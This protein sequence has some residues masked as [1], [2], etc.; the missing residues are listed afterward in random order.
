MVLAGK[1]SKQALAKGKHAKY[2]VY[3]YAAQFVSVPKF[4][5]RT[6]KSSCQQADKLIFETT[7]QLLEPKIKAKGV[8]HSMQ[9]AETAAC[10]SFFRKADGREKNSR[11]TNDPPA[12]QLSNVK[13]FW[14]WFQSEY[15][16]DKIVMD[17][18]EYF[19]NNGLLKAQ[20]LINGKPLG[21]PVELFGDAGEKDKIELVARLAG[22]IALQ[23]HDASLVS[24]Y[25]NV[26][27]RDDQQISRVLTPVEVNMDFRSTKIMQENIKEVSESMLASKM[28]DLTPVEPSRGRKNQ[29]QSSRQAFCSLALRRKLESF[30]KDPKHE[31]L[32]LQKA[33]LPV[34]CYRNKVIDL[35]EVSIFSIIMGDT[36]SGKTTQVPQIV[37]EHAIAK[38]LGAECNIM[39]TQPRR[40]AA[41]SVAHRVASERGESLQETVG[42][43]VRMDSKL[44]Q[45]P[46]SITY[47]TTGVLLA[48]LQLYPEDIF[49]NYSHLIIDEVHERDIQVDF[50]LAVLKK[51]MEDRLAVGKAFP[52][53]VLMSATIDADLFVRY[54]ERTLSSGETI[55]CPTLSVPGRLFP[56][57][58]KHLEDIWGSLQREYR[59]KLGF[60]LADPTAA[61]YIKHECQSTPSKHLVAQSKP[62]GDSG[63]EIKNNHI[64]TFG[65]LPNSNFTVENLDVSVDEQMD[66]FVP[67]ALAAA[68][69]AH[70]AK[71]T[72][73]GAILTFLPGLEEILK[74]DQCLRDGRPLGVNFDDPSNFRI[75]LLH[76]SISSVTQSEVFDSLPHGCRKI[77]LATNIAETSVTIRDV[78][79]VVDTGKLREKHYDPVRRITKLQCTWISKSNSKQRAGRAGRVQDGYYYALFSKARL[80]TMRATGLPEMLRSDLDEVCLDV[81]SQ[82][83]KAPIADFLAGAIE[84]PP[85][86]AVACAVDS[87][88]K[89]E[90]L[91]G[92]E[93]LTPLG[94]LL[95]SL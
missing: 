46:G 77:I 4:G 76:S 43:Q 45:W 49:E 2:E 94:R 40:I 33:E 5:Y 58:E 22:A 68:V 84:P 7:L 35:V 81:K 82:A 54:F 72:A 30:R 23:K 21:E 48:R 13:K 88:R 89:L 3:Q 56:V 80:S 67:V 9:D 29:H 87:L 15:P 10:L 37:F 18:P 47:C 24:R 26:I 14:K 61:D 90:A 39:C 64:E 38:D 53:V 74:L 8:G 6:V 55:H 44:P 65:D 78:R 27:E 73:E 62:L 60:L 59:D 32:R 86:Q 19:G 11:V 66:S 79:Y 57:T 69:V 93:E 85:A 12:L 17:G 92:K 34:N 41:T 20:V 51:G 75:L 50:L 31:Q 25:I 1:A 28:Q 95:V 83:F 63:G 52:K 36:G 42:Y 16:E 91:T 71:T 70:L